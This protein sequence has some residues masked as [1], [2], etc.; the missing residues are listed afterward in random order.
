MPTRGAVTC[1]TE[2]LFGTDQALGVLD[3]PNSRH[4]EPVVGW[5]GKHMPLVAHHADNSSRYGPRRA[6]IRAMVTEISSEPMQD[7]Q[8]NAWFYPGQS[9]Q[10]FGLQ[11]YEHSVIRKYVASTGAHRTPHWSRW[12]IT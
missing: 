6:A 7:M 3:R 2:A 12:P 10:V 4:S 5:T 8:F 1:Q 9:A 11:Q